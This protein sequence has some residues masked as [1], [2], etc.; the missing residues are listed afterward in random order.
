MNCEQ[1]TLPGFE[2]EKSDDWRWTFSDY[3]SS[4]LKKAYI[5]ILIN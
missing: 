1:L 2:K 5:L 4:L 3:P